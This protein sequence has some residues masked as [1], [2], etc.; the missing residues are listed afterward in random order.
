MNF[1]RL[2]F[3]LSVTIGSVASVGACSSSSAPASPAGDA[4]LDSAIAAD[5]GTPLDSGVAC[6]PGATLYDRL[7]GYTGIHAALV[8][9]VG[10]EL[11]NPEIASY[12]FNQ[13]ASPVPRAMCWMIRLRKS[14]VFPEPVF[15]MT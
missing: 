13:M 1:K 8:A 12:F 2:M 5:S 6:N 10:Q 11:A 3:G 15:P 4:G 7:G 9:I 14:V